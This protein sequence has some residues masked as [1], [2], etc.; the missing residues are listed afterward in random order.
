MKKLFFLVPVLWTLFLSPCFADATGPTQ[1]YGYHTDDN[2]WY[3]L[4]YGENLYVRADETDLT[5]IT[6]DRKLIRL[7]MDPVG[8]IHVS[9][10]YLSDTMEY[11][12]TVGDIADSAS[13]KLTVEDA[14]SHAVE[15]SVDLHSGSVIRIRAASME[16]VFHDGGTD[17]DTAWESIRL[18][19]LDSGSIRYDLEQDGDFLLSVEKKVSFDSSKDPGPFTIAGKTPSDMGSDQ[20]NQTVDVSGAGNPS[21]PQDPSANPSEGTPYP[22]TSSFDGMNLGGGGRLLSCSLSQDGAHSATN[23]DMLLF[24]VIA[25]LGASQWARKNKAR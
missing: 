15:Q 6:A 25:L 2:D 24:A 12:L 3:N 17:G 23:L 5:L 13:L 8:T 21:T 7:T 16:A 22:S 20:S 1:S 10:V 18:L 11:D 4:Y 9:V 19:P 14:D